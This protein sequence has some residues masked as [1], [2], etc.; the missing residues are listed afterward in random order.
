M[1]IITEAVH[2]CKDDRLRNK[3][4]SMLDDVFDDIQAALYALEREPLDKTYLRKKLI[5]AIHKLDKDETGES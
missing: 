3:S 2:H 1:N 4:L 5:R